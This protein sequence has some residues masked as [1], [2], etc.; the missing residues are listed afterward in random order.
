MVTQ[1]SG[2]KSSGQTSWAWEI[3]SIS[4][5]LV[6]NRLIL[7]PDSEIQKLSTHLWYPGPQ[8]EGEPPKKGYTEKLESRAP[9]TS[10][11]G[12]KQLSGQWRKEGSWEGEKEQPERLL[13]NKKIGITQ[14]KQ[15]RV[16]EGMMNSMRCDKIQASNDQS[17]HWI[18]H[19]GGWTFPRFTGGSAQY[20]RAGRWIWTYCFT[21]QFPS[22]EPLSGLLF[23]PDDVDLGGMG[24]LSA[25]I[26]W[27]KVRGC[28]AMLENAEFSIMEVSGDWQEEWWM[29]QLGHKP[30]CNRLTG[31]QE[32][33]RTRKHTASTWKSWSW[34]ARVRQDNS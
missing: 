8:C 24:L 5:R 25:W 27:E 17:I 29:N 4:G 18:P 16:Q 10:I 11:G 2:R 15:G 22:S 33:M 7:S 6:G 21:E 9:R 28:W 14:I 3:W 19:Y 31:M 12:Y 20:V 13:K 1:V 26:G 34:R 23:P 30:D 32:V